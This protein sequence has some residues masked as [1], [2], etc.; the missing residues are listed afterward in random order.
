M[1]YAWL[2]A[3]NDGP[4]DRILHPFGELGFLRW[5]LFAVF[6][7]LWA[8]YPL[9]YRKRYLR[10]ETEAMERASAAAGDIGAV[11]VH[12]G[13]GWLALGIAGFALLA[14]LIVYPYAYSDLSWKLFDPFEERTNRTITFIAVLPGIIG[15]AAL[16]YALNRKPIPNPAR[17]V[18]AGTRALGLILLF[19]MICMPYTT[20]DATAERPYRS[21]VMIDDS[22]SMGDT[23]R[24]FAVL[25][26]VTLAPAL[27]SQLQDGS[28]ADRQ[29][30]DKLREAAQKDSEQVAAYVEDMRRLNLPLDEPPA[31]E[32]SDV[33]VED[34]E[35]RAFGRSLIMTRAKRLK[36]KLDL[37]LGSELN[38]RTWMASE[39]RIVKA[40]EN[41]RN[42]LDEIAA[43]Q[44][45]QTP[46]QARLRV[47][48]DDVEKIR[49]ELDAEREGFARMLDNGLIM[50]AVRTKKDT[51]PREQERVRNAL[52]GIVRNLLST[53]D[54][55]G[56]TRWDVAA[57]L[58]QPGNELT[59]QRGK[60]RGANGATELPLLDLLRRHAERQGDRLPDDIYA[61]GR[62]AGMKLPDQ[63]KVAQATPGKFKDLLTVYTFSAPDEEHGGISVL[64]ETSVE[65]LDFLR[66]AGK[67]TQVFEAYNSLLSSESHAEV[68]TILVLSDGRDTSREGGKEAEAARNWKRSLRSQADAPTVFTAG[69]GHPRPERKL[70]LFGITADDEV[71]KDEA[72]D[73]ELKILTDA[74]WDVEVILCED[75]PA[76]EIPYEGLDGVAGKTKLKVEPGPGGDE[77][78]ITTRL[79]FVPEK[80]GP[81]QYW[82][83]LNRRRLPG[84]DSYENNIA[85]HNLEVIDRKIRVLLID[86]RF[87]YETRYMYEAMQRDK[88]LEFQ[89]FIFDAD[90]GWAQPRSTYSDE[91][92]LKMPPLVAPFA[93]IVN[94]GKPGSHT[95]TARTKEEW[96]ESKYD[97]VII[98]DL[99]LT[100][101]RYD[102]RK[103]L[104]EFVTRRRGGVIWLAGQNHNP[105]D[106]LDPDLQ[107]I[108]PVK[109][110]GRAGEH[111]RDINIGEMKFFGRTPVGKS[112]DILRLHDSEQRQDELWGR[113]RQGGIFEAGQLDG[114]YWYAKVE[115]KDPVC[116]VLA[117]VA[118][119]GRKL[120]FYPSGDGVEASDALIIAREYD[121]GRALFVGTDEVWRMRRYFGDYY[122]Y[123]FWQN[124]VR[125]AATSKLKAKKQEIDLDTDQKRYVLGSPVYVYCELIGTETLYNQIASRQSTELAKIMEESP[126]AEDKEGKYLVVEWKNASGDPTMSAGAV[127]LNK[128]MLVLTRSEGRKFFYEGRMF[129]NS[130][131][132]YEI[133]ILN[134]PITTKN[135][136][137][138]FV[139][140]STEQMRELREYSLN[141]ELLKELASDEKIKPND[142][143]AA[144]A[145]DVREEDGVLLRPRYV[146]FYKISELNP[147]LRTKTVIEG[148]EERNA[149]DLLE[150]MIALT[151]LFAAEWLVRKLVR[152]A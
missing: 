110:A 131:G 43:E 146:P 81:H 24:E 36:Q 54:P 138:F 8:A 85:V 4:L 69:I 62:E 29:L 135:P 101:L 109:V 1:A 104:N 41:L 30:L 111:G 137:I 65:E 53:I 75:N 33:L 147:D 23:V 55:R 67:T 64:R 18:L 40:Q 51:T 46:N 34:F 60:N 97:V 130:I 5:V 26:S 128:G 79:R 57:E 126:D 90:D 142:T 77:R 87:R 9:L 15:L 122:T 145:A 100:K 21:I 68:S 39:E 127:D 72:V 89:A 27:V 88:S 56:P 134:E 107:E 32:L 61:L 102:E 98:G 123:R 47:L 108:M 71:I 129:P 66:P 94:E 143:A 31:I 44:Q 103:W 132:K 93:K 106:Y 74:T 141:A 20:K 35:M 96:F 121:S 38:L 124:A 22:L 14:F 120:S 10:A 25:S 125:W 133:N 19:F 50:R 37:L 52:T 149:F 59:I 117:R 151:C 3:A 17:L 70:A 7:L 114:F 83:K 140:A 113:T 92:K 76:N 99:D 152:L 12:L 2:L 105:H 82:V 139:Q 86:Q 91:V 95:K 112:N 42:K 11:R 73:F 80:G 63:P 150:L 136:H 49:A 45:Q 144:S 13:F 16:S 28:E 116:T 78:L 119:N 115:P 6:F 48:N 148:T 84:E 118:H 58:V